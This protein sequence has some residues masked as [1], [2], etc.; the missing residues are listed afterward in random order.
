[1]TPPVTAAAPAPIQVTPVA[2]AAPEIEIPDEDVPL[3]VMDDEEDVQAPVEQPEED[4]ETV[5]I[6]DEEV[7]L[8]DMGSTPNVKH[9]PLHYAEL[10]LA[11]VLG[12]AYFGS[13]RKQR[14][15]IK[16]LKKELGDEER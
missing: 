2:P 3:A 1:M 14:K 8:A 16:E 9:T 15:E 6:T 4:Q 11:A 10:I 13:N 7:P 5:T 12:G